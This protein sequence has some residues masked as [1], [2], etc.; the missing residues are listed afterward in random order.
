M[1]PGDLSR[2]LD[3]RAFWLRAS[4]KN[5]GSLPVERWISVG[6][7]RLEEVSLFRQDAAGRWLRADVGIR[8]PLA[9]RDE[10]GRT[11][12][13]FSL[14]LPAGSEQTLWIRVASGT[15]ID[16]STT[17]WTPVSFQAAFN[18]QQF[19]LS[20]ALGALFIVM[21]LAVMVYFVFR[22]PA[23]LFFAVSMLGEI[24]I[25][26]FRSGELQRRLLPAESGMPVEIAAL[27]SFLAVF[28]F[29]AFFRVFVPD[30]QRLG[31]L[32]RVF[33]GLTALTVAAQ[34][35][36]MVFDYRS[37]VQV[38]SF[39][40]NGIILLGILLAVRSWQ[41]G[42]RSAGTFVLSFLFVA[43][44]ELLRLGA[45]IG[46][47]PF[48]WVEAMAGPWAL[49]MTTPLVLLSIFQRSE[50][51]H[52][53]L[54]RLEMENTS[55]LH[56]L[57]Q[58]S[59]ELRSPLNTILGNAQLMR[60]HAG[61]S[62]PKAIDDIERSGAQL[63][64]MIDEILD[65]A[66]GEAGRLE[67]VPG[68]VAW[69]EFLQ[70]MAQIASAHASRQGNQ[71]SLEVVGD[72]PAAV[73]VDA[74]RLHQVLDNLL[75]NAARHTVKGEIRLRCAAELHEGR[76][77]LEFTVTDTGEGIR[78]E[79][80]E[81]I[82]LPFERGRNAHQ[83]GKGTGM[84][85]AIA[86]RLV[87]AMGGRIQVSSQLGG[88]A[89][90]RFSLSVPQCDSGLCV[91]LR[92]FDV[93]PVGYEGPPRQILL[94]EDDPSSN[95]ILVELLSTLGFEVNSVSSGAAAVL[96]LQK[97][98]PDLVLVDQHMQEVGGWQVLEFARRV[99]ANLPVFLISS[100]PPERPEGLPVSL[101][102]EASFLKPLEHRALIKRIGQVLDLTWRLP[103]TP[104]TQQ[105]PELQGLVLPDPEILGHLHDWLDYGQVTEIMEYARELPRHDPS[106]RVYAERLHR[107]AQDLDFAELECLTRLPQSPA[108]GP[109]QT[110]T[111]GVS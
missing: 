108:D 83:S 75:A 100:S 5:A 81:R 99:D 102:F 101:Q 43:C 111:P 35:W 48:F 52:E 59:H 21:I 34:A 23:F 19:S 55:R 60:R 17:V 25:E 15:A 18:N 73:S 110:V 31:V 72:Q 90:F 92:T 67:I 74:Q 89:T 11:Y 40:V 86:K 9:Q 36:S 76:C 38:W 51:V 37:G 46:G 77:L 93:L 50:E 58:M 79:D 105:A 41:A 2:G 95:A 65:H 57:A 44:L 4:L 82:F 47:L 20:L 29:T 1:G 68:T 88:G 70:D 87:E 78:P 45:V 94:A 56:F 10:V 84:G 49:V 96:A 28:G 42:M 97:D 39:T 22:A 63:L 103:L 13:A 14:H 62:E 30:R 106:L 85:L 6:H 27:G 53:K 98:R 71:F 80:V 33:L 7:P 104:E 107:A 8:T 32:Y 66:R 26:S 69:P 3:A 54:V 12:G 16:L 64:R 61:R 24:L 109:V 91:P